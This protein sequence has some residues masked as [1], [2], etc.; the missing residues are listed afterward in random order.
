MATHANSM[1][2]HGRI[3]ASAVSTTKLYPIAFVVAEPLA[4]LASAARRGA[5]LVD[6]AETAA[7]MN[8][9]QVAL[10][11]ILNDGRAHV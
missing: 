1:P 2:M 10:I 5:A 4:G 7:A 8:A 3:P 6:A 9:V 11:A